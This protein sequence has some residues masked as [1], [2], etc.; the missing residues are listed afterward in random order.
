MF[1]GFKH[2]HKIK[3]MLSVSSK[4]HTGVSAFFKIALPE[5]CLAGI[6][7]VKLN[8]LEI[9][10]IVDSGCDCCTYHSHAVPLCDSLCYWASFT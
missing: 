10:L 2:F 4:V 6:N 7:S 8:A 9:E 1:L 3:G 5:N